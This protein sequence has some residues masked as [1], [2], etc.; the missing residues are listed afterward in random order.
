M[1][2]IAIPTILCALA[3][4]LL[5]GTI[6]AQQL[7]PTFNLPHIETGETISLDNF[8]GEVILLDFFNSNCG[9]CFRISWEVETGIQ[10]YYAARNGNQHGIKVQVVGI[11]SE[12]ATDDDIA[13]YLENIEPDMV[14]DDPKGELLRRYGGAA[15][16][17]LAVVD[18]TA[19]PPRVVLRQA[20]YNGLKPLRDVI[21]SITGKDHSPATDT[22]ADGSET[23]LPGIE[24]DTFTHE[25]TVDIAAMI[26]SDIVI[27]DT[28]AEY[29]IKHPEMEFSLAASYR[30][31][32]MDFKTKSDDFERDTRLH[33]NLYTL[34]GNASFFLNDTVELKL[35]SGIYDGFQTYRTLWMDQYYRL[36]YKNSDGTRR[37]HKASPWGY[38]VGSG[39]RWEYLEGAGY[40]HASISYQHDVVSPGYNYEQGPPYKRMRDNYDTISSYLSF[41][42]VLTRRLRSMIEVRV[43]NTTARDSRLTLQG[44]LNYALSESWVA[45]LT[46]GYATEDPHFTAK[47]ASLAVERDWHG[48][49]FVSLFGRYYED[50]S[51]ME[52]GIATQAA[53]PPLKTY[54]AGIG[55]R[56]Q[57]HNTTLKFDIGPCLTRYSQQSGRNTELDQL[58]KDR[59]WL[60]LQAAVQYKF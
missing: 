37:Y 13:A 26:A 56:R 46:A 60:S 59:E 31:T 38:S 25:A 58:Y 32:R 9:N 53:A 16:P 5:S 35:D 12:K 2:I 43:D 6:Q 36:Q 20:R 23:P 8:Q 55:V 47:S 42:N 54:Q 1:R 41:E 15:V 50:T 27:F 40:I 49:W 14:L 7:A 10:Q 52:K 51:E 30:P 34:S 18:A 24:S 48:T 44:G 4:S 45:R 21:D 19:T 29:L 22:T 33:G 39:L 28:M 57:G 3:M 11:N 17:Y